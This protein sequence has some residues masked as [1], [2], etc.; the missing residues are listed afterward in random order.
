MIIKAKE[1]LANGLE[2]PIDAVL[3]IVQNEVLKFLKENDRILKI[4]EINRNFDF[5]EYWQANDGK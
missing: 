5:L 2:A 3:Y 4:Q 1:F